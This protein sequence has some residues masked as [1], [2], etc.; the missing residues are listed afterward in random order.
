MLAVSLGRNITWSLYVQSL[1]QI[2]KVYGD[3]ETRIIMD[4][5]TNFVYILSSD[6]TTNKDFSEMLGSGTRQFMTHSGDHG[7]V[8]E[9]D[10]AQSHV[11]GRPLL[12]PDELNRL[13]PGEIIIKID[14]QFPIR[15]HRQPFYKLGLPIMEISEMNLQT[16]SGNKTVVMNYNNNPTDPTADPTI[17]KAAPGVRDLG[18]DEEMELATIELAALNKIINGSAA[19]AGCLNTFDYDGA[20]RIA[21]ELADTGFLAQVEL[22]AIKRTIAE[23]KAYT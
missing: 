4:Q 21:V 18:K 23:E 22:D 1:S 13:L 7:S 2:N 20:R 8:L 3:N 16:L 9:A 10:H 17:Y 11:K 5:M 12:L 15:T 6:K 19:F 14:R